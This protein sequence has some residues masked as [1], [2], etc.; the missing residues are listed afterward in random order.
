MNLLPDKERSGIHRLIGIRRK[1]QRLAISKVSQEPAFGEVDIG[2]D[3]WRKK[4]ANLK[5]G[6]PTESLL[7]P[8]TEK[9]GWR[10]R[11]SPEG[12]LSY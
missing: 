10:L 5:P 9:D 11:A 12:Q 3:L 2:A 7:K 1:K 8:K 4:L 6:Y